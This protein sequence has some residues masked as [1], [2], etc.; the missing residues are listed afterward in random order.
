M[1]EYQK[2]LRVEHAAGNVTLN[3]HEHHYHGPTPSP[4]KPT[5]PG[6]WAWIAGIAAAMAL[7]GGVA[8][9]QLSAKVYYCGS[10]NTVKYHT[11]ATCMHLV[12][13][14]AKVK[15]MSLSQA[16]SKMDICRACKAK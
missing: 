12:Q 10:H 15:S 13:C 9:T 8:T 7:G 11:D 5:R 4:P 3:Q 2:S 1:D 6:R 16:R 14:G